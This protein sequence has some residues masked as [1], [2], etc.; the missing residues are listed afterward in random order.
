MKRHSTLTLIIVSAI[1]LLVG[2]II[3][4]LLATQLSRRS[5]TELEQ[6]LELIEHYY[7]DSVDMS[8]LQQKILPL[9]VTK[10][11]PHSAYISQEES[12]W[13]NQRLDGSFCG[14]GITFNTIID[15]P[16]VVDIIPGGPA[17]YAGLR[18][19]D[20]ILRANQKSLTGEKFLADSVRQIL[21][22]EC[23]SVVRL[24]LL[25]NNEPI[26]V[27]VV[28]SD[29]PVPSVDVAFMPYKETGLIRIMQ[30]GR[31]TPEEFR[32]AYA[33]L[34]N[35]GLK[36]LI[37]DLRDNSGG[38]LEPAIRL[39]N[40]FLRKGQL[41]VYTQ[42]KACEREDFRATGNGLMQDIPL[43]VLVNEF[44]ASSSEVFAG[45]M[46]DHDRATIIGRRTFGKGL[47]QRP[48]YL[49]DSA[50]L[51]LTIARYYSPSGRC[52]QKQYTMGDTESYQMD[53]VKRY[54]SGEMYHTDSLLLKGA[55]QF[56]TDAGHIVYGGFGILP[57]V[58][59]PV[60]SAGVNSYYLRLLESGTMDEYAFRYV[61]KNRK[62]LSSFSDAK[63]LGSYLS[64]QEGLI[65]DYAYFA[66]SKGI[67]MRS[68]MLYES[69]NLLRK[70]LYGKIVNYTLGM[71]AAYQIFNESD[72]A[73]LA[74]IRH[75]YPQERPP[76]Q[77]LS[78]YTLD[79]NRGNKAHQENEEEL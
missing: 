52:I 28:R 14:I 53:L 75:F 71:E 33:R 60:D 61:D 29:V 25:R 12:K 21:L 5:K 38:Y 76:L 13:E 8:A 54:E 9:L 66:S 6:V 31:N 67:Q 47:I 3:S 11:D 72:E 45:A 73:I 78:S 63:Q 18:A 17:E 2:S 59:I 16:V 64:Y 57:S 79:R 34:K 77:S 40:E 36:S 15:T 50:Q 24:D 7:V 26:S 19:G 23:A 22:G 27:Q 74:A 62:K 48:F 35:Q 70:A 1:T 41:I 69:R 58:F 68:G 10:L 30:W 49:Q 20:R 32:A 44:S 4:W 46:Q 43:V 65:Y 55:Q 39:A 42:G 56:K 37:I 51:R